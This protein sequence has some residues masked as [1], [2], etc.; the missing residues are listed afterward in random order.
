MQQIKKKKLQT[1]DLVLYVSIW[2]TLAA[3]HWATE[4]G[5]KKGNNGQIIS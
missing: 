5:P 2:I 3:F 4:R 1:L